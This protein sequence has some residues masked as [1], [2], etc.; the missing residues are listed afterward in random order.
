LARPGRILV[1]DEAFIDTLPDGWSLAGRCDLPG[2]V[3]VRSLTKTWGLAGL[4]VGY[5]LAAPDLV[6]DLAAAAPLWPVSTPALAAIEACVS[7]A[8]RADLARYPA[9]LA[10]DREHLVAGLRALSGVT[11]AGTPASSFVLIRLAGADAARSALRERGFAV[12]R[13]DTFPGLG[14]DWLR[15]AVRDRSTTDAFL[16]AFADVLRRG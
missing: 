10:R 3:V 13:G 16:A 7:P 11:V 4:R 6:R 1:V 2:L 12:R 8:A 15:I 9:S 14:P 5:L